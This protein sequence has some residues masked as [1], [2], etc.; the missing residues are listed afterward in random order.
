MENWKK[1][2]LSARSG[3]YASVV[4]GEYLESLGF[5]YLASTDEGPSK[6]YRKFD[7]KLA[8]SDSMGYEKPA[9][10]DISPAHY[11]DLD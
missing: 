2:T 3:K 11:L 5:V 10:V 6:Y 8:L 4:A 9:I 1:V 7:G